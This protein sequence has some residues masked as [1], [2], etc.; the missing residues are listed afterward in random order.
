[1]QDDQLMP[2][3]SRFRSIDNAFSAGLGSRGLVAATL[4]VLTVRKGAEGLP[5]SEYLHVQHPS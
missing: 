2:V 4:F 1:M 5:D 3:G